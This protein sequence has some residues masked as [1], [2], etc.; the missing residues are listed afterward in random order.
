MRYCAADNGHRALILISAR[1]GN[2]AINGGAVTD[3]KVTQGLIL[4]IA[5][6]R[7][8][9]N[10]QITC[11]GLVNYVAS[12]VGVV[13]H[14]R[15]IAAVTGA[16]RPQIRNLNYISLNCCTV[17]IDSDREIVVAIGRIIHKLVRYNN[18]RLIAF[19]FRGIFYSGTFI[20]IN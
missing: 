20:N 1:V 2:T 12:N 3:D 11:C 7:T 19:I 14:E 10:A 8:A 6:N 9:N 17:H 16:P 13:Q 4:H 5:G 15:G 18:S